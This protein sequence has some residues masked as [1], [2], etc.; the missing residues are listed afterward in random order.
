MSGGS[1]LPII[2]ARDDLHLATTA[3]LGD[4]LPIK[5]S[6]L[7]NALGAGGVR[8]QRR[9]DERKAEEKAICHSQSFRETAHFQDNHERDATTPVTC[10]NMVLSN[11]PK[12]TLLALNLEHNADNPQ[13]MLSEGTS[14]KK[15]RPKVWFNAQSY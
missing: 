3:L 9:T 6:L 13:E 7:S 14:R 8:N 11:T 12:S 5:T 4:Q 10:D 2:P 15:N 1:T